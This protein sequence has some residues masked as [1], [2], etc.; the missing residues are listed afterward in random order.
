MHQSLRQTTLDERLRTR[1]NSSHS[2]LAK[3]AGHAPTTDLPS[4]EQAAQQQLLEKLA[5]EVRKLETAG[6][7]SASTEVVSTG[8]EALDACLPQQGYV[9]GSVIEYLRASPA[10]GATY[11]ATAA[12]ASALRAQRG[13]LVL[14]ETQA[15]AENKAGRQITYPPALAAQGIDL[16]RVIFVRPESPADAMWAVDQASRTHAV[17]AVVAELEDVDDRSARR[18]Q[19]AAEAGGTLALLLRNAAARRAP[20]W[21]E[22]QW[23]VRSQRSEPSSCSMSSN[24]ASST[25]PVR[26]IATSP[27]RRLQ[28]QLLRNRGG[29]S[30]ATV[31]LE[32][33]RVTGVIHSAATERNRYEQAASVRLASE[34]AH[35]KNSSRRAAAS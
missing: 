8:C 16:E 27:A 18:L 23:L 1:R 35:P 19:L 33:D 25:I 12:A 21:A 10:C 28:V 5:R 9:P 13:Y 31:N 11:L 7:R 20:S 3:H 2:P 22:V 15:C 4:A 14:V 6:R 26:T 30:G 29:K 32:V 34:L 24:G 17:S